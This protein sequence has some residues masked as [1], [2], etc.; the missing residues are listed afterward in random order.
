MVDCPTD[1]AWGEWSEWSSCSATCG[2]GTQ[3]ATRNMARHVTGGGEQ[4]EG[5]PLR[6]QQCGI[7]KCV[8]GHNYVLS[9]TGRAAEHQGARLGIYEEIDHEY[10]SRVFRQR[11]GTVYIYKKDDTWWC[12]KTVGGSSAYLYTTDLFSK[13][14]EWY[15]AR[16][17]GWKKDDPT[18]Q[19]LPLSPT[20]CIL[21]PSILIT[22]TG[23]ANSIQP[24]YLGSFTLV[25]G[26]FSAG[27]PVWRNTKGKVLKINPGQDNFGVY[28]GI[29]SSNREVRSASGPTCPTDT[30]AGHSDRYGENVWRYY[31]GGRHVED[32]T[33]L[34]Q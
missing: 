2:G 27:R 4:C 10:G 9:S 3:Y 19:F 24:D 33:I 28:D 16:D 7:T 32:A 21:Q 31:D 14:G 18:L 25:P 8:S 20:S 13:T 15:Y 29:E 22:S 6:S 30:K 12:G 26:V 17:G 11:G 34:V 23:R 5:E 1:C